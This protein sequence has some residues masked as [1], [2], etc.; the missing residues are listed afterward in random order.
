MSKRIVG[1]LCNSSV[2]FLAVVRVGDFGGPSY[3]EKRR[4][5]LYQNPALELMNMGPHY[6]MKIYHS[7]S[8]ER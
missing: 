8:H 6:G 5:S 2:T 3:V 4:V 1:A 7:T